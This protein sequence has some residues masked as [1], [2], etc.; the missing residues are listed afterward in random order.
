MVPEWPFLDRTSTLSPSSSYTPSVKM[1]QGWA[2]ISFW[3]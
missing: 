1:L 3:E 2:A